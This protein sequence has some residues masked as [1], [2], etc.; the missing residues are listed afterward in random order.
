MAL[1]EINTNR[2]KFLN[3]YIDNLTALEAREV[4]D[5]LIQSEGTHYVVTPNSDIVVK[6]QEDLELKHICDHADLILTDGQ[7]L[8]KLS[9]LLGNPIKERVC[10]TDFIWE[11]C[12]LADKKGYSL[13][14][15]GGI[16]DCHRPEFKHFK[17]PV[18]QPHPF[19]LKDQGTR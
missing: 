5:Y 14:F 13:F 18:M 6:M 3:T 11:V 16:L 1:T 7:I 8:V 19:L 10:M 15:L 9:K 12:E 17:W 2:I 4:V